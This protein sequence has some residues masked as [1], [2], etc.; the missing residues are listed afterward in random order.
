MKEKIIA[1][2]KK[3]FGFISDKFEF[4]DLLGNG[5]PMDSETIEYLKL[6]SD[7]YNVVWHP[8]VYFFIGNN[9]VYRVGVSMVNSRARV[10][11][12]LEA[13]TS[14]NGIG[15]WD[16][17]KFDDKSILLINVKD[18]KDRHWLL[19]I[20]AYFEQSLKPLI[21]ADRIG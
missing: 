2:F 14:K 19:A 20:E 9:S 4:L 12:H 16:I 8:G 13:C 15:I 10:M 1:E 7:A 18:K 5:S 3:E 17:D 21:G 11:Q 6:P